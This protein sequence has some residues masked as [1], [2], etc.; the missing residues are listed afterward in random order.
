MFISK[1]LVFKEE[2]HT[3]GKDFGNSDHLLI[4]AVVGNLN[5]VRN[6]LK[7]RFTSAKVNNE[8]NEEAITELFVDNVL[9]DDC[10]KKYI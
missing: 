2:V 4:K 7:K 3:D 9:N 6:R 1:K 10:Y 5:S 8:D